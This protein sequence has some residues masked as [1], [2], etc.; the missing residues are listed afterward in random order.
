VHAG[1]QLPIALLSTAFDASVVLASALVDAS[2]PGFVV[3][4]GEE[5]PHATSIGKKRA[6]KRMEVL[7]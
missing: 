4:V 2:V 1:E 7:I 3:V 5:P 6:M